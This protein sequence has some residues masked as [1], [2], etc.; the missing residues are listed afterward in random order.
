MILLVIMGSSH[1]TLQ[2]QGIPQPSPI[3]ATN[4]LN[5]MKTSV[6]KRTGN[7]DIIIA[8]KSHVKR[9]I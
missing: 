9:I 7:D 6:V 8:C 3:Q 1:F 2:Y 5:K 4:F